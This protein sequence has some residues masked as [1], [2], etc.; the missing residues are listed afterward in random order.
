MILL[1]S[2]KPR[3]SSGRTSPI[4]LSS[5][6]RTWTHSGFAEYSSEVKHRGN[7]TSCSLRLVRFETMAV[8]NIDQIT[9]L[10]CITQHWIHRRPT[11]VLL[12]I[13]A[14]V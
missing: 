11:I 1:P 8:R 9:G 4:C 12:P 7:I 3:Q 6:R 10:R 2:C 14:A 5:G 13:G